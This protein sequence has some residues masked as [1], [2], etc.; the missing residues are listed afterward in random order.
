MSQQNEKHQKMETRRQKMTFADCPAHCKPYLCTV[1]P[2]VIRL[3]RGYPIHPQPV[4]QQPL[5]PPPWRVFS[6]CCQKPFSFDF[7]EVLP[8]LVTTSKINLQKLSE[9]PEITPSHA[10]VAQR[11][12][13]ALEET[14][15]YKK[16]VLFYDT[17]IIYC[18][19]ES[20]KHFE[21]INR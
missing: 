8:V 9:L 3:Q 18:L 6:S 11:S 14:Q 20:Q 7:V 21:L 5:L 10:V 15:C 4:A 13:V 1:H 2:L 16:M 12:Q 17:L 19:L